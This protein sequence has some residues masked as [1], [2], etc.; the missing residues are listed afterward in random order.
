[1]IRFN[2]TKAL[3]IIGLILTTTFAVQAA[4]SDCAV[5]LKRVSSALTR[6]PDGLSR[7]EFYEI[8]KI[9]DEDL[10]GV[11]QLASSYDVQLNSSYYADYVDAV[12]RKIKAQNGSPM[13]SA[14]KMAQFGKRLESFIDKLASRDAK[15]SA[16]YAIAD[17]VAT[18]EEFKPSEFKEVPSMNWIDSRAPFVHTDDYMKYTEGYID[19]KPPYSDHPWGGSVISLK[20]IREGATQNMFPL[21]LK[22]HDM[23]HIHYATGHPRGPAMYFKLARSHNNVRYAVESAM[24][25]GVDTV[26]YGHE[27]SI[28]Q[29]MALTRHMDLEEA[30]VYIAKATKED[31]DALID[32]AQI[33][34]AVTGASYGGAVFDGWA[35][36]VHGSYNNAGRHGGTL[37]DDIDAFVERSVGYLERPEL[38]KYYNFNTNPGT[39]VDRQKN[40]ILWGGRP[41]QLNGGALTPEA[42]PGTVGGTPLETPATHP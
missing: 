8:A 32:G 37:D 21:Q 10:A 34:A 19:S 39:G 35:P 27:S 1:M 26:Q 15:K 14:E 25:E 2:K 11:R 30:M 13:E 9:P 24:Y 7:H 29:Y 33:R 20:D 36:P 40:V 6:V 31:L 17:A 28:A 23:R 5:P 41:D 18:L 22:P 38:A 4:F 3:L 42:E 16:N 12:F